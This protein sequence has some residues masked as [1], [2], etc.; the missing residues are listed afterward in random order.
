MP[1][2]PPIQ[3]R[4][5]LP[6]RVG[7]R[8]TDRPASVFVTTDDGC[9]WVPERYLDTSCDPAIVTTGYDIIELASA[10]EDLT[11]STQD[12]ADGSACVRSAARRQEWVPLRAVGPLP[13][14]RPGHNPK[15]CC[16]TGRL[17][18]TTAPADL[19]AGV[20]EVWSPGRTHGL[21]DL[22]DLSRVCQFS[23]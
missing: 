16:R 3:V 2:R 17:R 11:L 13:G 9:G 19:C 4:P 22:G 21:L 23:V 20:A 14:K 1:H 5:G 7:Q 8:D 10:G 12:D 18:R 6:A 15:Y